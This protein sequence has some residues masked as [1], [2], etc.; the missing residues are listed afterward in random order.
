MKKFLFIIFFFISSNLYSEQK[1]TIVAS[2]NNFIITN[3]DISNEIALLKVLNNSSRIDDDQEKQ[4]ALEN[5]INEILKDTEIKAKNIKLKNKELV[6]RRYNELLQKITENNKPISADMK[7]K[8]Y[9]K[10]KLDYQWNELIRQQYS[11]MISVNMNEI[12]EK[13]D[14]IKKENTDP[15]KFIAI[16]EELIMTEKNKK[17]NTYSIIHMEKIKKKS[18]IKFF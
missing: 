2:V 4:V 14:K 10:I 9:Q 5:M 17:M 15:N 7:G 12:N 8:I 3:L 1:L 16:K 6:D 13:L 18:L 11:W